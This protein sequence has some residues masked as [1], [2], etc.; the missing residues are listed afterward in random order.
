VLAG[1]PY[2]ASYDLG[3]HLGLQG[4]GGLGRRLLAARVEGDGGEGAERGDRACGGD[5]RA[6][7]G[8]ARRIGIAPSGLG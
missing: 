5:A 1:D 6:I 4:G 3:A 2:C 7:E 8:H